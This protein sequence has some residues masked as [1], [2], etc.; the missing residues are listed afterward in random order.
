MRKLNR[1]EVIRVNAPDGKGGL[2]ERHVIVWKDTKKDADAISVYC[3]SQNDGD[4][5]NN[6]FV[7]VDSKEGIQMGLTKDTY[8]RPKKIINIPAFSIIKPVG[9][10]P[11]MQ[12][13]AKIVEDN[14]AR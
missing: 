5:K 8:I 9:K 10:C 4:D 3:T 7:A 1:G 13:I 11:F 12:Q 2:K 14:M 6:I